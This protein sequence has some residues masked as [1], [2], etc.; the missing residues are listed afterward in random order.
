MSYEKIY[1]ELS[2]VHSTYIVI[3]TIF[4]QTLW[5]K[6]CEI[7]KREN[8]HNLAQVGYGLPVGYPLSVGDT[9]SVKHILSISW[10]RWSEYVPEYQARRCNE[11]LNTSS[12]NFDL[13]Q[14]QGWT[15]KTGFWKRKCFLFFWR[16]NILIF[17]YRIL[18]K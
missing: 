14:N 7:L 3:P 18:W 8:S 13:T 6:L 4:A 15:Q 17:D 5:M 10:M 1:K 12:L 16:E 2:R 11:Y 9:N